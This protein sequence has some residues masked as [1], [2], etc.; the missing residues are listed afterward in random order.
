VVV[1]AVV[2]VHKLAPLQPQE[3]PIGV[4]VVAVLTATTLVVWLAQQ[5]ALVL[6]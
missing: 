6:L 3:R 2:M 1:V 4:A 5:V